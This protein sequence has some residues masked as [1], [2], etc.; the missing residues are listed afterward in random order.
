[1]VLVLPT[2][3]KLLSQLL[4]L[5]KLHTA[6]LLTPEGQ[7]ISVASDPSRPK[8][9]ARIVAGVSGEVWQETREQG[10]GM[11]DSELGRILVLPVMKEH[12]PEVEAH[13]PLL[14]LALNSTD[15]VEWDNLLTKG[16]TLVDH[17]APSV[18]N[19]RDR[20]R[21]AKSPTAIA[22]PDRPCR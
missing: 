15:S 3:H 21:T 13:E 8:D 18:D 22:S 14:L 1:M 10:Y 16:K 19:V 12:D 9:K 5:P 2:L 20:S 17:L 4:A 11:V 6:V 7:L